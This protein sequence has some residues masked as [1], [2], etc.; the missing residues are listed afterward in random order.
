MKRKLCGTRLTVGSQAFQPE[1]AGSNPVTRS[2]PKLYLEF[3]SSGDP[4]YRTIRN[5]HY[6]GNVGSHG[7]QVHFLIHYKGEMVGIISGGSA[8]YATGVRDAFFGIAGYGKLTKTKVLNGIVD[9][10]VFRLLLH[11]KNLA[12]RIVA[13]WREA[14]AVLWEEMYG[15][16]VYGYETFVI[17]RGGTAVVDEQRVETTAEQ[18]GQADDRYGA[19]Y[20]ADNWVFTGITD[21]SSK[22]HRGEGRG[23]AGGLKAEKKPFIREPVPKKL[24]FCRWR[25]GFDKALEFEYISSWRAQTP[26]EKQRTKDLGKKRKQLNGMYY[27]WN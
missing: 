14:V 4:R 12:S 26:E 16:V 1:D 17:V 8:V 22:T 21:G 2:T 10:T 20:T 11:E 7:Q 19:L 25:K 13:L 24:V 27:Y 23:L 15:A 18:V 3:C 6:V 5:E 9:N